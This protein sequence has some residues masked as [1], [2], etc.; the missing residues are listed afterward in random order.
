VRHLAVGVHRAKAKRKFGERRAT[1]HYEAHV[2]HGGVVAP[3]RMPTLV[4]LR[5]DVG[6]GG[7]HSCP[8]LPRW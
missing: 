1:G 6:L 4:P 2:R 7:V 8:R 5:V 3:D